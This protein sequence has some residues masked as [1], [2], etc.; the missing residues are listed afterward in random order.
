MTVAIGLLDPE[1]EVLVAADSRVGDEDT[2]RLR[3]GALKS[4]RVNRTG[5]LVLAGSAEWA[6]HLVGQ[7]FGIDQAK[8]RAALEFVEESNRVLDEVLFATAYRVNS[9]LVKYRGMAEAGQIE[10]PKL[11]VA[12]VGIDKPAPTL[13]SWTW[14]QMWTQTAW[15][16]SA[17]KPL[18]TIFGPGEP[19]EAV[20]AISDTSVP[21][22]ERIRKVVG[23][24]RQIC[25][26][27][28]NL[29]IWVRRA[30]DDFRK[31]ALS[32]FPG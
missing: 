12:L 1:G 26:C 6:N 19:P 24:F 13:Y 30:A 7:L 17:E 23:V 32:E 4:V 11:N 5:A 29:D 3:D 22:W 15:F 28:V 9:V 18:F 27:G 2:M 16:Q 14:K 31:R 8:A 20:E 10:L 25:P 21:V